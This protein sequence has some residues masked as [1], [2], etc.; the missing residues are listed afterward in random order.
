MTED[1]QRALI[2]VRQ[3]VN[4][5]RSAIREV[6]TLRMDLELLKA[7][8]QR[9]QEVTAPPGGPISAAA[10]SFWGGGVSQ[11]I[12]QLRQEVAVMRSDFAQLAGQAL[13]A[14][15]AHQSWTE[16]LGLQAPASNL[17]QAG[18]GRRGFGKQEVEPPA[19]S[20]QPG[21]RKTAMRS[22]TSSDSDMEDRGESGHGNMHDHHDPLVQIDHTDTLKGGIESFLGLEVSGFEHS[23]WDTALIVT[24]HSCNRS[25][26]I[27]GRF[28]TI[29]AWLLLAVNLSVQMLWVLSVYSMADLAPRGE[30]ENAV[31]GERLREGQA[32]HNFDP[33]DLMTKTQQS[34]NGKLYNQLG[35]QADRLTEYL[36]VG[37][38]S[39]GLSGK[40]ICMVAMLVWV[41][42]IARELHRTWHDMG[43]VIISLPRTCGTRFDLRDGRYI[44]TGASL[45]QKLLAAVF[46]I[47]PRTCVAVMLLYTGIMWLAATVDI[48][49][50]ILTAVSLGFIKN[51]DD[52]LF[53][54]LVPKRMCAMV[55]NMALQ[56]YASRQHTNLS[57]GNLPK[58]LSTEGPCA[59][60]GVETKRGMSLSLQTFY[61]SVRFFF[62]VTTLGAA[63]HL[64]VEPA[65]ISSEWALKS[66]CGLDTAFTYMF[67]PITGSP[68]FAP[69]PAHKS[70]KQ[71]NAELECFSA[72]QYEMLKI[73]A[74]F[75]SDLIAEN[76]TL[77]SLIH[78]THPLCKQPG[79]GMPAMACPETSLQYLARIQT[80]DT[81]TFYSNQNED[82]RD[83][84]VFFQVLRE[85][86]T[87]AKFAGSQSVLLRDA[88][89]CRDIQS[90]CLQS[91]GSKTQVS[92]LLLSKL[93]QTCPQTCGR[94][95]APATAAPAGTG[96]LLPHEAIR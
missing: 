11:D 27:V 25:R 85:V 88:V 17:D 87:S 94:C 37:Y 10:S 40:Y 63:W 76:A 82:C 39:W 60:M 90:A 28:N 93:R 86:C 68:V 26:K 31:L 32:Y 20:L 16:Y 56:I 69:V 49:Q 42:I 62:I 54:A 58:G 29:L 15:S 30:A 78:G 33:V 59:I 6:P 67:H 21:I 36:K 71:E 22:D 77:E 84:D 72:A 24:L 2:S 5:L 80:M 65:V 7:E 9:M 43:L 81:D 38:V 89:R 92:E 74:G 14:Q 48:N 57:K 96:S 50:L 51:C 53:R 44:I 66:A 41:V 55:D 73:R 70:G 8:V 4:Q 83:Q 75:H 47:L 52:V 13:P 46:V 19:A 18:D 64:A 61:V 35:T 3:E 1:L 12:S 34:C 23:L 79:G 45:C 91:L 95:T